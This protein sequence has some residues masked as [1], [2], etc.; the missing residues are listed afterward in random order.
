MSPSSIFLNSFLTQII[1]KFSIILI[2]LQA[3]IDILYVCM[4]FLLESPEPQQCHECQEPQCQYN[5]QQQQNTTLQQQQAQHA[6]HQ[7]QQQLQHLIQAQQ[8][9]MSQE[10]S[11]QTLPHIHQVHYTYS[12]RTSLDSNAIDVNMPFSHKKSTQY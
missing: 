1:A 5:Q 10:Q 2:S 9:L 11:Y 3:N 8:H 12:R 6:H 4:C 7:Q